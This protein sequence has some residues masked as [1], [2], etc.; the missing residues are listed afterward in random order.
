VTDDLGQ[1]RV[2]ARRRLRA[3][4][5][6]I[7]AVVTD[8]AMHVRIDASGM[9]MSTT[10]QERVGGVGDTF[11]ISM[12]RE[13]LGDMPLG[14]YTVVNTVT[15]FEPVRLLEWTVCGSNGESIGHVYGYAL[16]PKGDSRTVVTS[17]CDWQEASDEWKESGF[18]PVISSSTLRATLGILERT[19]LARGSLAGSNDAPENR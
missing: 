14:Q 15:R 13:A 4:A 2:S 9:L 18:F 7:W 11:A 8:P 5:E 3:N 17:Y 10:A 6:D 12:D 16:E 1:C 19:L